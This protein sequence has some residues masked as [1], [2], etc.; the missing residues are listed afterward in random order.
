MTNY[1]PITVS[2]LPKDSGWYT[3]L[4]DDGIL[5]NQKFYSE[6]RQQF[7]QNMEA[8]HW[9]MP[10][11]DSIILTQSDLET[12]YDAAENV[13]YTTAKRD[14]TDRISNHKW[15]ELTDKETYI[16]NLLTGK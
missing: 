3:M 2:E 6:V 15:D 10:V 14:L 5:H 16:N 4:N 8:T 1:K 7:E 13:G 12:M 9:L 11:P